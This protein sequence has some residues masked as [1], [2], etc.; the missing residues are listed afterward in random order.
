M[1]DTFGDRLHSGFCLQCGTTLIEPINDFQ[2]CSEC[3]KKILEAQHKFEKKRKKTKKMN[4]KLV[5]H[6]HRIAKQVM[7][8]G[9]A[10]K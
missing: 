3:T 2:C 5:I 9:G 7:P 1:I 4:N 10:V 6:T 8:I